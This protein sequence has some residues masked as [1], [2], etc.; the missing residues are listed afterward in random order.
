MGHI[1]LHSAGRRCKTG[2]RLS[3]YDMTGVRPVTD[4]SLLSTTRQFSK[5]HVC[6]SSYNDFLAMVAMKPGIYLTGTD[7]PSSGAGTP[8]PARDKCLEALINS[9][10]R[11]EACNRP[12]ATT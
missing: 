1:Y 3:A 6:P 5:L 4:R 2:A 7:V 8:S 10:G 12:P 9:T 11:G